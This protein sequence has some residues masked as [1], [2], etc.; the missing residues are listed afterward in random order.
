MR[1]NL[2][3]CR[4]CGV[5]FNANDSYHRGFGFYNQ[6]RECSELSG[7]DEDIKVK[8][9]TEFNNDGDWQGIEIVSKE[10][11]EKIKELE[12]DSVYKV[13]DEHFHTD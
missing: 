8:A 2:I 13:S 4:D 12:H 10:R 1:I 3:I 11:F 6:C 5:E 7:T 9:I